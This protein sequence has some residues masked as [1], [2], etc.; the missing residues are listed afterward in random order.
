M[1]A[2]SKTAAYAPGPVPADPKALQGY[3]SAEFQKIAGVVRLLADGH[4]D[5]T[6]VAPE[7]PREGD[8]RLADGTD[9]DPGSGAGFYGYY[10]AAWVKLG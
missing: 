6:H 7:R 8:F 5:T 3:L 10:G 1:V 9:W 4:V 2:T